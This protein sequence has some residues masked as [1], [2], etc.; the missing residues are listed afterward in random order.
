MGFIN[1]TAGIIWKGDKFLITQRFSDDATIPGLWEFPGGK[2]EDAETLEECLNR[3]IKEELEIEVKV[4]KQILV[5]EHEYPNKSVR[6]YFYDTEYI[7][8]NIKL[9]DHADYKWIAADEID[10]YEFPPA[11]IPVLNE[12]KKG[13]I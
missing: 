4:V 2:L 12:I 11:D 13:S 10:N 9:N 7:S 3:E 8:G 5:N 6:L 1:V